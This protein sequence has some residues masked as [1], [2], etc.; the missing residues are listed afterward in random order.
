MKNKTSISKRTFRRDGSFKIPL[1]IT[2]RHLIKESA[3]LQDSHF[4]SFFDKGRSAP[5]LHSSRSE[6]TIIPGNVKTEITTEKQTEANLIS[7]G[8]FC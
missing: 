2:F 5:Y 3:K 8:I 1:S 4:K 7:A 6:N